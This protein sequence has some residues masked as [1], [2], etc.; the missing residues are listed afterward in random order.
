MAEFRPALFKV[1]LFAVIGRIIN[2]NSV[3]ILVNVRTDQEKQRKLAELPDDWEG[4]IVDLP[5]GTFQ[6][7]D[8]TFQTC[9]AR[10]IREETGG[11]EPG[12]FASILGPFPMIKADTG[13]A[14]KPHDLAFVA[15]CEITGEPIP[16][17][18]ASEHR[19]VTWKQL[20]EETEFRLPGKLG[21]NGR[22]AK[23]IEAAM[24]LFAAQ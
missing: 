4:V 23:M 11:C 24:P 5:G 15:A 6:M 16:T 8:D 7:G 12:F 22:M 10:E 9:L 19:W 17:P 3:G 2:Q 13:T 18:E 1:G 14:D 20:Q 21:K